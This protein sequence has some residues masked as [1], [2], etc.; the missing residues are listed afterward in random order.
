MVSLLYHVFHINRTKVKKKK[1]NLKSLGIQC[2]GMLT[3]SGIF[4]E[5]KQKVLDIYWAIHY[6]V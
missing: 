6:V 4:L 2:N 5:E 3:L 1:Q